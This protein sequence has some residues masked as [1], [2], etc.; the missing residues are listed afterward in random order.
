MIKIHRLIQFLSCWSRWNRDYR[1]IIAIFLINNNSFI[2][3]RKIKSFC[4]FSSS[5]FLTI[6]LLKKMSNISNS[7]GSSWLLIQNIQDWTKP[8]KI[9]TKDFI[10]TENSR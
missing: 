3:H 9:E 7:V 1:K 5:F 6:H 2:I 10:A 4:I 8:V